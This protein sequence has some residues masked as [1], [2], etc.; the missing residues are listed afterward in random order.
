M[1]EITRTSV[2]GLESVDRVK[3]PF[4]ARGGGGGPVM[5]EGGDVTEVARTQTETGRFVLL[6][7]PLSRADDARSRK[8]MRLLRLTKSVL[9]YLR[10]LDVGSHVIDNVLLTISQ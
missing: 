6:S 8:Y 10:R 1:A 7:K 3:T 2:R 4:G 5:A 9:E